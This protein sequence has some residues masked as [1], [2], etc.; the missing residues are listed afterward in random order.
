MLNMNRILEDVEAIKEKS[1]RTATSG[2]VHQN[3]EL[4]VD[5]Y[6]SEHG[7]GIKRKE[8]QDD[9][10]IYILDHCLFDPSHTGKDAAIIRY[11]NGALAYHCFHNSC[12]DKSWKDARQV[13]SGNEPLFIATANYEE[14][15]QITDHLQDFAQS[16]FPYQLKFPW[17]IFPPSIADSLKKCA[18]SC[19]TSPIALAG[20][21]LSILSS[22]LGRTVSISPKTSWNE[23]LHCWFVDIRFSGEGK[24]PG[25]Q[26]LAN[27]LH[28]AQ[29]KSDELF[30]V[31]HGLWETTPRKERG[32]EPKWNRSYF[33]S[34]LTLEGIRAALQQGHGGIACLLNEISSFITSQG[35]Y[36]SGK[37][38][39]REAWLSLHD[40]S[41]ARIV[42]AGN[43][44]T[45]QGARISI[46][47]GIQPEV[48]KAVFAGQNGL[49]LND[50][51]I[52]R[53]L[54]TY[55]PAGHYELTRAIWSDFHRNSWEGLINKAL[56][57]ADNRFQSDEGA[58]VLRLSNEAWT[59]F[60]DF[61]NNLHSQK[62]HFPPAYR[63]F[64]PKMV[65]Y[66][67]RIS[68]L[69]H[70]MEQ[71]YI[72][73]DISP[74]VNVETIQKAI[75]AV[76][77]YQGHTLEALKLLNGKE[78]LIHQDDNQKHVITAIESLSEKIEEQ[79]Y[80]TVKDI[81]DSFNAVTGKKETAKNIGTTLRKIGLTPKKDSH[82][83]TYKIEIS[84][85]QNFLKTMPAK[86]ARPQLHVNITDN[87]EDIKNTMSACPPKSL[88]NESSPRTLRTLEK[89]SP[90][91]NTLS[92]S[93]LADVADVNSNQNDFFEI[94]TPVEVVG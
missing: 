5:I 89:Q 44:L 46:C 18:E 88:S 14:S 61:R 79:G 43:S 63:G 91:E 4:N 55:E 34:G 76:S 77:F 27:V 75:S 87:S 60:Q 78:T 6:L 3:S 71:L 56:Q 94:N 23:P 93:A 53:F 69:I 24:T 28:M 57:W 7:I 16:I 48:F 65:S 59:C 21:A 68:G 10:I 11:N 40:G 74:V 33:V 37:G 30:E 90:L 8:Q 36:K 25:M 84:E 67:L 83:G 80:V 62:E 92:S 41:P 70:G 66:V 19:A 13:I 29:R 51:T 86:S 31:Q 73:D 1:Q 64:I 15:E 42:R 17:G 39:D 22:A 72:G 81:A 50:G 52:F 12:A 32:E 54:M 49:F 2:S 35:Q 45:I 26:L 82:T 85:I 20:V 47:G 38:D 9:R 58:L